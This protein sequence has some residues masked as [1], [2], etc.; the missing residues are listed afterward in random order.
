MNDVILLGLVISL[1]FTELTGISPGGLIVPVYLALYIASPIRIVATLLVAVLTYLAFLAL[2]RFV[3]VYGRR[4]FVVMVVLSIL[5]GGL[6]ANLTVFGLS[7]NA[8]GYAIG[9]IAANDFSKQG[10]FKSLA[11]LAVVVCLILLAQMVLG[12]LGFG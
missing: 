12:E 9:G 11:A 6:V 1:L 3:I 4:R 8:I 7:F 2:E 5:I 10:V